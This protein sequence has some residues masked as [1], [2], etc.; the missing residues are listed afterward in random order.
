MTLLYILGGVLVGW[1][2]GF[3]DSN[4]RS[5]KKIQAAESKAEMKVAEAEKKI[6]QAEQQLALASQTSQVVQDDPGLLRIKN[7]S[8][9]FTLEM[10]GSP[11]TTALSPDKKKRLIELVTVIRPWLEGGQPAPMP[12]HSPPPASF[13][14]EPPIQR[15]ISRTLPPEPVKPVEPSLGG[16]FSPPP[17]AVE[18]RPFSSLSIVGQIDSILQSRLMNTPLAGHGIRLQESL[19]GGVEVYVGLQKFATVDDV[20]DA[21]IKSAIRAAIAEWEQKF[22]PGL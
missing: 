4:M 15:P 11:I 1:V 9:R 20:P 17:K 13:P 12:A 5:N 10:D 16:I 22:T 14:K 3:L 19:Q 18:E 8:G 21:T 2:I 6:V 7:E